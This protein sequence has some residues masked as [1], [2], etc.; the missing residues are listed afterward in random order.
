[1][2]EMFGVLA[3]IVLVGFAI[4]YFYSLAEDKPKTTPKTPMG[5]RPEQVVGGGR[6]SKETDRL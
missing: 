2:L 6:P 4:K 1:M 3:L 5:E